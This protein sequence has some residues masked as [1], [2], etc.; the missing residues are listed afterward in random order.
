MT[1]RTNASG[2]YR[3]TPVRPA[4]RCHG[5]R[6]PITLPRLIVS[7][8]R[9]GRQIANAKKAAPLE[10]HEAKALEGDEALREGVHVDLEERCQG[11]RVNRLTNQARVPAIARIE[12]RCKAEKS[13]NSAR[14]FLGPTRQDQRFTM[15]KLARGLDGFTLPHPRNISEPRREILASPAA[16]AARLHDHGVGNVVIQKPDAEYLTWAKPLNAARRPIAE[17][18]FEFDGTA[19][20]AKHTV[21]LFTG[22]EYHAVR[23]G[24]H[25]IVAVA[26]KV[27]RRR[28]A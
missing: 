15:L 1:S 20:D 22:P 17:K 10:A 3:R 12:L 16:D 11:R 8:R 6:V 19:L 27:S 21:L 13:C 9:Q 24:R 26:G 23:L 18:P 25:L 5:C 4:S 28:A 2:R 7:E 14:E